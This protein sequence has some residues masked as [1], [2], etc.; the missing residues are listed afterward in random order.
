MSRLNWTI[1]IMATLTIMTGC[2][3]DEGV[4]P[5]VLSTTE[6]PAL[7]VHIANATGDS[8][9]LLLE[10]VGAGIDSVVSS[11]H[12]VFAES[13]GPERM[14]VLVVGTF[15]GEAVARVWISNPGATTEAY[16]VLL[17]QVASAEGYE[18]QSPA[19]YSLRL[20]AVEDD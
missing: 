9:A 7:D 20:V 17:E 16:Q 4:G 2:F 11:T 8:G 19:D 13:T 18:Q 12:Q 3:D 5:S 1:S 6:I 10:V 14:R 15:R